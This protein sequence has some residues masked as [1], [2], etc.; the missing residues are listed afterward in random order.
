MEDVEADY[1][2]VE[3]DGRLLTLYRDEVVIDSARRVV[4]RRM[5]ARDVVTIEQ[6]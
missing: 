5:D 6:L 1:F 3:N 4:V 2:V